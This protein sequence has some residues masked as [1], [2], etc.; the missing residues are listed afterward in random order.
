M[1][2]AEH[3]LAGIEMALRETP[4]LI[5]LDINLPGVDGY[6]VGV[7]LKSFP[8]LKQV[9]IVAVTAYAMEGVIGV[10][11]RSPIRPTRPMD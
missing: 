1:V 6:E 8:T 4:A 2:E 11:G 9:P 7:I 3:G 5:L 10:E